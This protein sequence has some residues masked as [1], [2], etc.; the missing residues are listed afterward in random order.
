MV[1]VS[2]VTFAATGQRDRELGL[3]GFVSFLLNDA[4]KVDGVTLRKTRDGRLTLSYP[5]KKDA[6]GR[7]FPY[8]RPVSDEVRRSIESQV[9]A[10]IAPG[11]AA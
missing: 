7:S 1:T 4:I 6:G 11:G 10:A 5:A 3:F 9:F 8:F 2:E